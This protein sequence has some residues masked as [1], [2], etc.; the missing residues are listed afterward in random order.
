MRLQSSL[1]VNRKPFLTFLLKLLWAGLCS[2]PC[3]A[4]SL[5]DGG[6]VTLTNLP[7]GFF[8]TTPTL[9]RANPAVASNGRD[10]LVVWE[11]IQRLPYFFQLGD[12]VTI[13]AARVR[14][15]DGALLDATP[16]ALPASWSS[17]S[18]AVASDGQDFFVVWQDSTKD[19]SPVGNNCQFESDVL[20]ARVRTADGRVLDT[21]GVVVSSHERGQGSPTVA[22]GK[23]EYLVV[24]KDS[25]AS[26]C[27]A[28]D[29]YGARVN[30]RNGR[31]RDRDGF[32]ISRMP[33]SEEA[34]SLAFDGRDYLVAWQIFEETPNV[35]S[36]I[37]CTRLAGESM[38]ILDRPAI[39]LCQARGW[40]FNSQIVWA[41]GLFWLAWE[42]FPDNNAFAY[43]QADVYLAR[44]L[45]ARSQV[46]Y[47]AGG[48]SA[49][50]G[51]TSQLGPRLAA[52]SGDVLLAWQSDGI[53][54]VRVPDQPRQD[55]DGFKFQIASGAENP[56][57]EPY[58]AHVGL[59][60]STR[61]FLSAW[62]QNGNIFATRL[63][64]ITL[65]PLDTPPTQVSR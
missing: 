33:G 47:D 31:V 7:P 28:T 25:R 1:A 37:F 59:A 55:L 16:I 36:H 10:F 15:S 6:F 46:F 34:P 52:R 13:R 39:P 3:S 21:T 5:Q 58:K 45:S 12:P 51:S 11:E 19:R 65:Q 54:G 32:A 35:G 22:F 43:A 8:Q 26:D 30:P 53:Y 20:G 49:V 50:R 56:T 2:T 24:W 14:G 18:P 64:G 44:F 38:R 63:H 9:V 23:N 4:Q 17:Q 42:G 27:A 40:H 29:I 62:V 60:A 41:G 61:Y 57:R 48:F